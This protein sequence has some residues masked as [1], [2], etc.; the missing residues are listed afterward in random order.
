[1]Q[2][3]ITREKLVAIGSDHINQKVSRALADTE[4]NLLAKLIVANPR[5]QFKIYRV[6]E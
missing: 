6:L 2:L 4:G 5:I 3:R 1:M